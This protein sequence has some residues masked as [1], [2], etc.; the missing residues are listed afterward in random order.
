MR[1]KQGPTQNSGLAIPIVQVKKGHIDL[2][3]QR[4]E[5]VSFFASINST[6]GN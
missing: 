6:I 3:D 2:D 5:Y 4:S 1:A